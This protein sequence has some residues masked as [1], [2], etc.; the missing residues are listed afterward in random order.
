MSFI[1]LGWGNGRSLVCRSYQQRSPQSRQTSA[2]QPRPPPPPP[3]TGVRSSSSAISRPFVSQVISEM[4][5]EQLI[6]RRIID[7]REQ[8]RRRLR[9][10]R[11]SEQRQQHR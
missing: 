3:S 4:R 7:Q 6:D 9:Q 2:G 1:V 11:E 10:Q 8:Q 5:S